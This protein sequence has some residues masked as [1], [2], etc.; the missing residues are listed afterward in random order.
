MQMT[1][2]GRA[3]ACLEFLVCFV[4]L[5][6]GCTHSHSTY[7][8]DQ[9]I[10]QPQGFYQT[11]INHHRPTLQVI[12]TYDELLS[13]HAALRL[14]GNHGKVTFWDPAGAYGLRSPSS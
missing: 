8:S 10:E 13:N 5:S 14:V 4:F 2:R 7:L 9:W 3:W 12:I 1:R 6:T 11:S